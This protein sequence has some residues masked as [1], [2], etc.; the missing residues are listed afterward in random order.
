M[1]RR[2]L[3]FFLVL[4]VICILL[5]IAFYFVE[6]NRAPKGPTI[7]VANWNIQTFGDKKANDT[8]KL[9][10]YVQKISKY[11][12]IFIQEIRDADTSS[13]DALCNRLVNYTCLISSRAGRSSSKEQYGLVYRNNLTRLSFTDYN[14]VY[15]KEFE[16]PPARAEFQFSAYNL[17]IYNIHVKP[18]DVQS[19]LT[20]MERVIE[21]HSN[22]Q[23]AIIIVGDLNADCDYYEEEYDTAFEDWYWA[24][25][26]SVDTTVSPR[27]CTYDRIVLNDNA[28]K[29]YAKAGVDSEGVTKELSDHYLVWATFRY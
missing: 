1:R 24:I 21:E 28:K 6:K 16:R 26:D 5:F 11:D 15:P 18:D 8:I 22:P 25:S 20:M 29:H 4:M 14:N 13:F 3:S 7:S 10:F 2:I 12:I 23:D 27:S 9:H 19:E 17:T